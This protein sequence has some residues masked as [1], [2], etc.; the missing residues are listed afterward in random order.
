MLLLRSLRSFFYLDID[1]WNELDFRFLTFVRQN[2][3]VSDVILITPVTCSCSR[4]LTCA[5]AS[6][7]RSS[8]TVIRRLLEWH[9]RKDRPRNGD[10]AELFGD[11]QV[12]PGYARLRVRQKDEL[13]NFRV[14]SGI[15]FA[16]FSLH[17]LTPGSLAA[18]VLSITLT[19]VTVNGAFVLF[20]I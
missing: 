5:F 13:R 17:R 7:S 1:F 2:S 8:A 10:Q 9:R 20:N 16:Y 6:S 4:L 19:A 15:K 11:A 14:S 12:F 3:P 18:G